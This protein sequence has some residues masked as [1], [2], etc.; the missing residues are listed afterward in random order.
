[1]IRVCAFVLCAFVCCR[2]PVSAQEPKPIIRVYT[3]GVDAVILL[4]PGMRYQTEQSKYV[5]AVPHVL[6]EKMPDGGE[7]LII[8]D[9]EPFTTPV[10]GAVVTL[11]LEGVVTRRLRVGIPEAA[12]VLFGPPPSP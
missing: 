12:I 10:A 3:S 11:R 1:M 8:R 6:T 4:P 9:R 7:K 5:G 2:L